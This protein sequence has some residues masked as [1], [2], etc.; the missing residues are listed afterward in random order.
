M[1]KSCP[2]IQVEPGTF[3]WETPMRELFEQWQV[4][5]NYGTYGPRT[6]REFAAFNALT[7][8]LNG[9]KG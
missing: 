5:R 6:P 1:C 8:L 9:M 3:A 4:W 2:Y 7:G